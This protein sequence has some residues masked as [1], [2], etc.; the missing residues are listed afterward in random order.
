[1]IGKNINGYEIIE[2]KGKGSFGTVYKCQKENCT[3][4][5][6]I[7]AIDYVFSEFAKGEDNRIT[8]EIEA[9]K[10]VQSVYVAGYVDD[11][12]Y[13]DNGWEYIYVVMDFVE[14][15]DF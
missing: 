8:R 2:F 9:L 15:Q 1:M 7:F 14:G 12:T 5:M 11:G 13:I 6:K 10:K 3:Y 4:A